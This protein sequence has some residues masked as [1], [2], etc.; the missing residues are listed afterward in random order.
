MI[1][2]RLFS[3]HFRLFALLIIMSLPGF[4]QSNTDQ[5]EA[6]K[7]TARS[8][9]NVVVNKQDLGFMSRIFS[10]D[11]AYH[12]TDGSVEHNIADGSLAAFLR[13]LFTG[14]PDIQYTIVNTIAE[15][16]MVSLYCVA[17]GT[18]K[19]SFLGYPA[20][21]KKVAF[22]EMFLYRVTNGK[23]TEAWN[24]VDRKEVFDQISGK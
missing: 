14:F 5:L 15:G 1:S 12:N 21:N 9:L 11:F 4:C 7:E 10:H 18:Q 16:D 2:R 17:T 19:G 24:V 3:R 23:L 22:K 20:T 13:E 8:Y 6:N